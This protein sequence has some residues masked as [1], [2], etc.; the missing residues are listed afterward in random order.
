M[1]VVIGILSLNNSD[2][3]EVDT[4]P[5]TGTGITNA[6][7]V[8]DLALVTGT[9]GLWQ[10]FGANATDWYKI[11]SL[12]NQRLIS[13]VTQS[14]TT[15]TYTSITEL[16]SLSLP[17]GK[18][19]F[20]YFGIHQSTNTAVGLGV[21]MSNVTA[22]LGLCYGKFFVS[23]GA[24]GTALNYSYDQITSTSN[25]NSV[26]ANNSN[27]DFLVTGNG[28]FTVTV[29]GTVAL[30]MKSSLGGAGVSVRS[31]SNLFIEALQ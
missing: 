15:T 9:L 31:G 28:Y 19:N 25:F 13:T 17:I 10:K 22:T 20:E 3:F 23:Q 8:G 5:N 21:R 14:N 2:I 29:A 1:S 27:Q 18:Y 26:L 16:T 12:N 30:Q 6:S 11:S 24:N 7:A 4:A